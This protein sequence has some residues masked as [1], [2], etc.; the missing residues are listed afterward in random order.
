MLLKG[1]TGT[2]G[3]S[4]PVLNKDWVLKSILGI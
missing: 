2:S 3:R 4:V 1:I